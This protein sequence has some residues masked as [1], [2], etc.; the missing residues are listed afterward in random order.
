MRLLLL[1]ILQGV[2]RIIGTL[3]YGAGLRIS[4]VLKLRIKD[5][6]F[7]RSTIFIF[8][9]KG[10]KDRITLFPEWV[11]DAIPKQIQ[12][13]ECIHQKDIDDGY[14]LTSLPPSLLRKYGKAV[15]NLSWQY[16]FP[17][18][19][20]CV[21]PYDGYVCRH[22]LHQTSF[23]KALKKEVQGAEILKRVTSHTF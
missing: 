20:R 23:R 11:K 16:V 5:F 15:T 3:M 14:G 7:S 2:H 21:H 17:S 6:V 4:G 12:K 22:H 8:R 1:I 18:T 13:V 19:T 9:S 10:Q